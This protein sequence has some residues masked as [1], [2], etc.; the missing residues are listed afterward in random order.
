[1]KILSKRDQQYP[2]GC[3]EITQKNTTTPL[4][5]AV[6]GTDKFVLALLGRGAWPAGLE[7]ARGGNTLGD[8][9]GD[10]HAIP[11]RVLGADAKEEQRD[12]RREAECECEVSSVHRRWHHS[13]DRQC[14]SGA[15][16]PDQTR[17]Q[18]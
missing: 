5:N 14:L 2:V 18:Q 3:V 17:D 7:S 1:M 12:D 8:D 16:K 11:R 10:R 6:N 4:W 9:E 13:L 15:T